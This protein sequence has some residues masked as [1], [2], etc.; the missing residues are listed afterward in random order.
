MTTIQ[1]KLNDFKGAQIIGLDSTTTIKLTGG[2]S[3]P[4]QGKV[5]KVTVGNTVM[6]FKSA[7]GYKNMV[8]RRLGKQI[9][10][11][12]DLLAQLSGREFTPG[13]R[14]WGQRLPDSPFVLHKDKLYLECIFLKS[15]TSK[16]Y[17]KGKEIQKNQIIGLPKKK[18]GAQGGLRDKV[19]IRT[20]ALDSILKVRKSREEILGPRIVGA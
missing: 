14:P 10:L 18:E 5:Q 4:M 17:F 12:E 8:N 1:E 2:K 9:D 7:D 13:P 11:S 6:I 20:F 3:N 16:F 19:I 15:G